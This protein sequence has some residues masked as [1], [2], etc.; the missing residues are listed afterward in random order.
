MTLAPGT[1][2]GPYEITAP[3]AAQS[4]SN[5]PGAPSLSR[6]S[7]DSEDPP[8]LFVTTRGLTFL[9][10]HD[11]D[12]FVCRRGHDFRREVVFG[13]TQTTST[14]NLSLPFLLSLVEVAMPTHWRW[15]RIL[16]VVGLVAIL[17]GAIDPLEGS[18]LILPG[19]GLL[20]FGAWLGHG[21]H[22]RLLYWSFAAVA[23]GVGTL[24]GLSAV[25]GLGGST[26]RSMWWSLL[27]LP[28]PVGWVMA[29]VGAI[30]RLREAPSPSV[31]STV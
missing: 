24:W 14:R 11:C 19:T 28:Y 17:V 10:D 4:T 5:A 8:N 12:E 18:L 2:L 22:R 20:A 13:T 31:P 26:G 9:H 1:R 27:L 16:V 29:L 21:R 25:G 15:S 3:I 7:V 6:A 30:R 23:V